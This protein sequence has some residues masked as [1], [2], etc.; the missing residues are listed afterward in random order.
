MRLSLHRHDALNVREPRSSSE[1]SML[2]GALAVLV[3]QLTGNAF[4]I[5]TTQGTSTCIR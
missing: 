4:N 5:R 1:L 2:D 3:R